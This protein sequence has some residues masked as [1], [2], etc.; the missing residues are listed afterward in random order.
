MSGPPE[1]LTKGKVS[2]RFCIYTEPV[3]RTRYVMEY[4]HVE[5]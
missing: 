5:S 2:L 3:G 1:C 4:L